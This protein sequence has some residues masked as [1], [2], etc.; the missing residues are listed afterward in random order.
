[1][2]LLFALHYIAAQL[3]DGLRPELIRLLQ[4]PKSGSKV[5]RA[6]A[7]RRIVRTV[8]QLRPR[9]IHPRCRVNRAAA[10]ERLRRLCRLK[11]VVRVRRAP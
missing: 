1:M 7:A 11:D 8:A 5:V 9:P 3:G 4:Q 10:R 2:A 6:A